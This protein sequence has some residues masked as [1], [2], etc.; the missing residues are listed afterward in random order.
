MSVETKYFDN[1]LDALNY[2]NY[3]AG[4]S[5][6][7]LVLKFGIETEPNVSLRQREYSR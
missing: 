4:F 7:H 2:S 5:L 6:K 3:L 1:Y